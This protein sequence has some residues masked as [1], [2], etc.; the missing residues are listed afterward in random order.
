M[1]RLVHLAGAGVALGLFALAAP[2]QAQ[3]WDGIYVGG[4]AGYATGDLRG[5]LV[6]DKGSGPLDIWDDASRRISN[7][8]WLAGA[9]VGYQ[10]QVGSFVVGI[11]ADIAGG[12]VDGDATTFTK[13]KSVSWRIETDLDALATA[14]A[15]IGWVV[16]PALLVYGTGGVAWARSEA[17][18]TVTHHDGKHGPQA[19]AKGDASETHVGWTAGAGAEWQISQVRLRAEWLHVDLG[20]ESYHL[21]GTNLLKKAPHTTDSLASAD[22]KFD[23]FRIGLT[24]PLGQ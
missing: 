8:G 10:R 21:T 17:D 7:D 13:T 15:R 9:Y 2:A 6:H 18:L 19:T 14:R 5:T 20:D 1:T 12:R 11:E 23:V 4:L 22:L 3:S 24:L 16:S